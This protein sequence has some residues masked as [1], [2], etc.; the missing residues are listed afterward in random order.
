VQVDVEIPKDVDN[1][2][3]QGKPK[4]RVQQ[5]AEDNDF[6]VARPRYSLPPRGSAGPTMRFFTREPTSVLSIWLR[7][8]VYVFWISLT[9][10]S[11]FLFGA[12]YVI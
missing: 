4:P 6:V 11:R 2:G 1:G 7:P 10:A 3:V 12:M 8:N 5:V 9:T